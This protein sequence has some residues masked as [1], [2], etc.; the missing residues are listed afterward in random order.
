[1]EMRV[2]V[3][4][5][6]LGLNFSHYEKNQRHTSVTTLISRVIIFRQNV[7]PKKSEEEVSEM[8]RVLKKKKS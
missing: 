7:Q 4:E 8:H 5:R 2:C 1:M 3:R 6:Q